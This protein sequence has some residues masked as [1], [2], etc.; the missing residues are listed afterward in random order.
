MSTDPDWGFPDIRG[1][2]HAL[3]DVGDPIMWGTSIGWVV[4]K[5]RREAND[6]LIS[7]TVTSTKESSW[8]SLDHV[9]VHSGAESEFSVRATTPLWLCQNLEIDPCWSA[10][11]NLF[12]VQGAYGFFRL[13]R[14]E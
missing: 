2:E 14:S 8:T 1:F 13:R 7:R 3:I 11:H 5:V 4:A 9:L 10:K 12:K 6:C